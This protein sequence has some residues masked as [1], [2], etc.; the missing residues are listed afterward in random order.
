[1]ELGNANAT[2][3]IGIYHLV[4]GQ[5]FFCVDRVYNK[6]VLLGTDF[7]DLGQSQFTLFV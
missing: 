5:L 7:G 3:F 1:M 6:P 4:V 2:P